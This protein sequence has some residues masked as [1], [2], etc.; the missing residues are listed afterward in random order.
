MKIPQFTTYLGDLLTSEGLLKDNTY[1]EKALKFTTQA[2]KSLVGKYEAVLTFCAY[3]CRLN[4][5][6]RP[7]APIMA[8]NK[9]LTM[10]PL[11]FNKG[12][13]VARGLAKKDTFLAGPSDQKPKGYLLYDPKHVN[14]CSVHVFSG[15]RYFDKKDVLTISFRGSNTILA[16]AKDANVSFGSLFELYGKLLFF[17]E[18]QEVENRGSH[19]VNPFGVHRGFRNGMENILKDIMEK[20]ALLLKENP[21]VSRIIIT[22]HSLGGA[23]APLMGLCLA[24][25]KKKGGNVTGYPTIDLSRIPIHVISLGAPKLFT[26]YARNVFNSLLM[27]GWMTFDRV[28]NRPRFPDPV[29]TDPIPAIPT[30]MNHPGFLILKTEYKTQSRTGRTKHISELRD[31]VAGIKRKG[32]LSSVKN[33]N[34]LPDYPEFYQWFDDSTM[35]VS[36]AEYSELINSNFL[37]HGTV[38]TGLGSPI[39][40]KIITIVKTLFGI[41]EAD[42]QKQEASEKP[43]VVPPGEADALKVALAAEAASEPASEPASEDPGQVGA[44]MFGLFGKKP[45]EQKILPPSSNEDP[46]PPTPTQSIPN[47]GASDPSQINVQSNTQKYKG[48]TVLEQPNHIVYSCQQLLGAMPVPGAACHL[49]YMGVSFVGA[50]YSN[51]KDAMGGTAVPIP[52]ALFYNNLPPPKNWSATVTPSASAMGNQPPAA[53]NI[54]WTWRALNLQNSTA[55]MLSQ[56]PPVKSTVAS[57][58]KGGSRKRLGKGRSGRRRSTQKRS[59]RHI[60]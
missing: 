41:S 37:V 43:V 19:T 44:G 33:Y 23:Y 35:G 40:K 9:L 5:E 14:Y 30:N 15:L 24:Q 29:G 16:F 39:A 18:F 1:D 47:R 57:V 20:V 8:Y 36:A 45:Q 22:G 4:Y 6:T 27:G 34:A 56:T 17:D 49:G 12:L 3:L 48:L 50:L 53:A 13:S 51:V 31:S 42:I 60:F 54:G 38:K 55:L 10:S 52:A 32:I 59:P 26:D 28:A 11:V 58:L 21:F 2:N 25:L 46:G 7:E